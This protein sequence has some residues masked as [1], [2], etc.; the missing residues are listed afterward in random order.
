M[1]GMSSI[2]GYTKKSA[3]Q[4]GS[5]HAA[6]VTEEPTTQT[7]AKSQKNHAHKKPGLRGRVQRVLS[8]KA[9]FQRTNSG[10]SW[11]VALLCLKIIKRIKGSKTT[12][13]AL[14]IGANKMNT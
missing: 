2:F 10:P 8:G 1:S 12:K 14:G 7:N 5:S 6:Q 3:A 13:V 4:W 11:L 9:I